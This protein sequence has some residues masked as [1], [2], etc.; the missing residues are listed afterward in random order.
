MASKRPRV[1]HAEYQALASLRYALRQFLHFSEQSAAGGGLTPQQHQALLAI[2]GF[3]THRMTI[4]EL[5]E[6][7]QLR[8]HSA[9]GLANRL[10]VQGLAR[11]ERSKSDRRQVYL[12]L[13]RRGEAVLEKLS[14][15]H[16]EELR[17]IGPEI[18]ALLERLRGS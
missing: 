17:R 2:K 9:V 3:R 10:V 18:K 1:S 11:R 14:A 6:R 15:T 13:S 5:A 8:H 16:K 4:G 12:L 7:L